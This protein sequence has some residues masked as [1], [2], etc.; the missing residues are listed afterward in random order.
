MP[1]RNASATIRAAITTTLRGMPEDSELVVWDDDSD[2]A[3]ASV[4]DALSDRRIRLF[5]SDAP[6]G[7]GQ[8]RRSL[9]DATDSE[10][11]ANMDADD[12]SLPWRFAG[13]KGLLDRLDLVFASTIKFGPSRWR[14]RPSLSHY[15]APDF[16]RALSFH[17]PV[18]HSAMIGRRTAIND[19]GGYSDLRFGQD[20]DLWL[21]LALD[22]RRLGRIALP[23][24]LYRLS[25]GQ[26]SQSPGYLNAI[27]NSTVA[28]TYAKLY[29]VNVGAPLPP[30]RDTALGGLAELARSFD[31]PL[32]RRYYARLVNQVVMV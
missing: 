32:L 16:R 22:G 26:A 2:D 24:V 29:A 8:A 27:K 4:V 31:S 28:D 14:L 7:S 5:R 1:A 21:R 10:F 18:C 25:A 9:M 11:V 13:T 3:T 19:V 15:S 12:I 6:V 17:A 23:G 20:Y 30:D